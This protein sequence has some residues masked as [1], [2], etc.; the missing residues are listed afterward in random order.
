MSDVLGLTCLGL[1]LTCQTQRK[2]D[3]QYPN[4]YR[5]FGRFGAAERGWEVKTHTVEVAINH[6][7]RPMKPGATGEV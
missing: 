1:K 2:I 6:N 3:C 5:I 4:N 7:E